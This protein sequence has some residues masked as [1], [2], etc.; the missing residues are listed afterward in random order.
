M[1]VMELIHFMQAIYFLHFHTVQY[2]IFAQFSRWTYY[3][4]EMCEKT[5]EEE[6][7][8]MDDVFSLGDDTLALR[9]MSAAH[10]RTQATFEC[11]CHIFS[12][13]PTQKN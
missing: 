3:P 12:Y 8:G 11:K 7:N 2:I 5:E 6:T 1:T 4:T 13:S 10:K 9:V